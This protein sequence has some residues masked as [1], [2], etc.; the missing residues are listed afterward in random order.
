MQKDD[1]LHK[2][3]Q[4]TE[5]IQSVPFLANILFSTG[6]A[7]EAANDLQDSIKTFLP[8]PCAVRRIADIYYTNAAWM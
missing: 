3:L 2:D 6:R 8:S 7:N 5:Q 4:S 1:A